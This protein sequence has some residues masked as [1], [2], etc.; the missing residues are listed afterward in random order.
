MKPKRKEIKLKEYLKKFWDKLYVLDF[1][2]YIIIVR[3]KNIIINK[4]LSA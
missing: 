3:L 1:K 2:D 4:I